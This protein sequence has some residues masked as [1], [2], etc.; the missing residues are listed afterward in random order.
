MERSGLVNGERNKRQ[1]TSQLHDNSFN[2]FIIFGATSTNTKSIYKIF[3]YVKLFNFKLLINEFMS[4]FGERRG[5]SKEVGL[6][7]LYDRFS[8]QEVVTTA[9]IVSSG[10]LRPKEVARV[11]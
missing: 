5:G 2:I 10:V 3:F 4:S 8:C 7:L 9:S 11:N 1:K 6:Q